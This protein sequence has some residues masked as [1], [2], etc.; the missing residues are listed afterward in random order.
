MKIES[1]KA[2]MDAEKTVDLLK[3]IHH[4][5]SERIYFQAKKLGFSIQEFRILSALRCA[6]AFTLNDLCEKIDLPKSTVSRIVDKLFKKGIVIREIPGNN[7]R[8]VSI[9]ISPEFRNKRMIKD[10]V[11]AELASHINPA[12]LKRI[13][14]SLRELD[15]IFSKIQS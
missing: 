2:A 11:M 8:V 9:S 13:T 14:A 6:D 12:A 3:S 4:K 10:A 7:R 1:D 5:M 15:N